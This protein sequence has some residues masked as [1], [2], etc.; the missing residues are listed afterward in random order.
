[1]IHGHLSST[2]AALA[3]PIRHAILACVASGEALVT[4]LRK[5]FQMSLPAIFKYLKAQEHTG[6][7]ARGRNAQ[8]RL[9]R[10][11]SGPLKDAPEWLE[12]YRRFW[13]ESF[14]LLD[15]YL[16]ELQNTEKKDGRRNYH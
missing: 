13:E 16:H 6:L 10:V 14:D 5:P 11:A 9:C 3:D 7:L 12:K 8:W 2:F 15:D 1:M 4:E